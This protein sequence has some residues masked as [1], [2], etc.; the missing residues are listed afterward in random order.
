M[1]F[2]FAFDKKGTKTS[3]NITYEMPNQIPPTKCGEVVGKIIITK[4]GNVVKTID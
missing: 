1:F 2:F 3:Y 4:Q